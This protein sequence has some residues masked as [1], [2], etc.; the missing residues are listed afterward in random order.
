M[1]IPVCSPA[2]LI[3]ENVISDVSEGDPFTVIVSSWKT[4]MMPSEDSR[5][6]N[7]QYLKS[8][9]EGFPVDLI[10]PS[11]VFSVRVPDAPKR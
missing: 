1:E 6:S 9:L 11:M 8:P 7:S 4:K 5:M 2:S 3:S 10:N